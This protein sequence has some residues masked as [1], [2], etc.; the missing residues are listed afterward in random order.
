[1]AR[2]C[3]LKTEPG[4]WTDADIGS[5]QQITVEFK[6]IATVPVLMHTFPKPAK[7]PE[8]ETVRLIM[9][10]QVTVKEFFCSVVVPPLLVAYV[11]I[12]CGAGSYKR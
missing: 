8:P 3:W 11:K 4:Q 6:I 2:R 1:M 7:E 12:E 10:T 5:I 9:P